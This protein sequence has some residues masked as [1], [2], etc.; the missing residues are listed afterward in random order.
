MTF[1]L[2]AIDVHKSYQKEAKQIEVLRGAT[3]QLAQGEQ[4]ALLGSSGAGKSTF[5][6][7]LGALIHPEKGTVFFKGEPLFLKK[8]PELAHF[9]NQKLGFVF[10]FH[11][12]LPLFN[13]L[14]NVMMPCLIAGQ[15]KSI[16]R[17]KA[18]DLL[19]EVGLK[20]RTLHFPSEL[21]GGEQQRVAIARA[22]I[23]EP[24]LVLADEPTGNLDL[25]N[26][27]YIFELLL[28]LNQTLSTTLIVVTHNKDL[29]ARMQRRV[30]MQNGIVLED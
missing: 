19:N 13:T 21:S 7:V 11:Y 23:L 18:L 3:L 15:S 14:E 22:L 5:L 28:K 17:K 30:K 8:E 10:Q 9:R 2:E 29:A 6:K 24:Q 12:L 25:E 4:V 1:L 27:N 26:S 16:A 20:E